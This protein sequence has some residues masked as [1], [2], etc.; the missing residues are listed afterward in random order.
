MLRVYRRALLQAQSGSEE[1]GEHR[2]RGLLELVVAAVSRRL[3]RPPALEGGA[4]PEAIAL[5]V[6][7]GNL[8]DQLGPKRLPREVLAPIP[9]ARGA[10]K[11]AAFGGRTLLPLTPLAPRVVSDG[12]ATVRLQELHQLG[13]FDGAERCSHAYVL[14]LAL[15]APEPQ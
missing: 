11:P 5:E 4:V 3:V 13:A 10:G 8:R 6:V 2:R 12:V 7:E 14:E 1:V 9:A 15:V